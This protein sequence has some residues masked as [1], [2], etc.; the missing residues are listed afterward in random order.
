MSIED[1]ILDFIQKLFVSQIKHQS[2]CSAPFEPCS[3][4][5]LDESMTYDTPL[6][7]G[8]FVDSFS[9]V[10]VL[11]FLE[12]EFSIRISGKDGGPS[13]F[14]SVRRMAEMVRRHQR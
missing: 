3:C 13:N 12:K 8:G 11:L 10:E 14:N 2:Y 7:A 6:I 1:T 9:M 5:K 4:R